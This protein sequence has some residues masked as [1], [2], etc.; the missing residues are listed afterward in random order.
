MFMAIHGTCTCDA[1]V[2]CRL[3]PLDP[4]SDGV[5]RICST[6]FGTTCVLNGLGG[7]PAV[8]LYLSYRWDNA[9]RNAAY[10][11]PDPDAPVDM[12][13]LADKVS[14]ADIETD[15]HD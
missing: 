8:V 13:E 11:P 1:F 9:R 15:M 10:G 3:L 7:V 6:G 5:S 2:L 4:A 14:M 12:S